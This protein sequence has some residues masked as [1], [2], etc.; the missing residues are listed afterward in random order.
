MQDSGLK[1]EFI[2]HNMRVNLARVNNLGR[3]VRVVHRVGVTLGLQGHGCKLLIHMSSFT[4]L[5]LEHVAA[6]ELQPRLVGP[7]LHLPAALGVAHRDRLLHSGAVPAVVEHVVNV[8]AR[9]KE[10]DALADG[11]W[12]K[13]VI[14]RALHWRDTAGWNELVVYWSDAGT[15]DLNFV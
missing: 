11:V 9:W 4:L 14:G 7:Q 10:V 6:V 1:G 2:E 12:L 5:V 13:E 8:V 3:E 15:E